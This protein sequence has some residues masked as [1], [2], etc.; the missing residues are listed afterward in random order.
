MCISFRKQKE[1]AGTGNRRR[2]QGQPERKRMKESERK[3]NPVKEIREKNYP[4]IKTVTPKKRKV[5][6]WMKTQ[7][8]EQG[9]TITS[10]N[11]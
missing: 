2:E 10:R 1:G 6:E 3:D 8:R 11:I 4:K 9:Q 5:E 7:Q